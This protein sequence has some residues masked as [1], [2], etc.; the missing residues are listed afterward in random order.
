M[1]EESFLETTN[2]SKDKL[3]SGSRQTAVLF[4]PSC[5]LVDRICDQ[6]KLNECFG[7]QVELK[8]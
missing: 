6:K 1:N 4:S 8:P 5:C 7:P 3:R 2:R